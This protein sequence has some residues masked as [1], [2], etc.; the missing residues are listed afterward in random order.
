ML[1]GH[2]AFRGDSGADVMSAILHQEPPD[3]VE[4]QINVSPALDHIVRRCLE[5]DP[6][7]RFQS[8]GDLAFALQELSGARTSSSGSGVMK[9]PDIAG[10]GLSRW[11]VPAAVAAAFV[12]AV[13]ATWF[14]TR[15]TSR[16]VPPK[17]SQLTYQQGFVRYARFLA[18][19]HTFIT[20]SRWGF[21]PEF[22][23]HVGSLDT[24][25]LRSLDTPAQEL[26]SVSSKDDILLLNKLTSIGPGYVEAGTLYLMHYGGGAPRP[27]LENV[28]YADWDPAG[29]KFAVV[30]FNPQKHVHTLEYPVGTVLYQTEGWISNPRFSRDGQRI[31]FLDHPLFGDDLGSVAYTDLQGKVK[32]FGKVFGSVQNV[33]WSPDSSEIWFSAS[34]SGVARTIWAVDLSGHH[35]QLLN[36]P[37]TMDIEDVLPNGKVIVSNLSER[38]VQMIVTPEFPQARDFTWMDWAYMN[39]FSADGKFLLFGDQHSQSY[40]AF[41]RNVDG[42]PAVR[43]GDGDPFDLSPDGKLAASRLP[44]ADEQLELLPTDAGEPHQLT[45]SN[46]QFSS[47]RFVTNDRLMGYGNEPGHRP[48]AFSIDLN[49]NMKPMTAEGVRVYAFTTDGKRMLIGGHDESDHSVGQN[50]GNLTGLRV[51][52]V[53]GG[54]VA[55]VLGAEPKDLPLDFNTDGTIIYVEQVLGA[56]R[57]ELIG[58]EWATGKRT[59]LH[60]VV[61]PGIPAISNGLGATISRDGKS[62]AYQYHPALSTEYLV[63]GLR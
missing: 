41:L 57:A 20:A 59:L 4:Q 1:S 40:G 12:I 26:A 43:L 37:G 46:I 60:D 50:H 6:G 17:F 16:P 10:R 7:Q 54:T 32:K 44:T 28:H 33:A 2:R 42:T 15:R 34:D 3:L 30:R 27:I 9:R 51:M 14:I 49:G 11:L 58:L 13:G 35:R 21:E 22:G 62:Y 24:P 55:P 19:G 38:R 31:A 56:T 61:A 47:A 52:D 63:E 8:A 5:K 18:D 25:G 53:D 45:H 23:L 39:R 48:R 29:E 36:A